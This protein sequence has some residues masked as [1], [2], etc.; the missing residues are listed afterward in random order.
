MRA[1]ID[2][3]TTCNKCRER[4]PLSEFGRKR[5][6]NGR[7]N[8]RSA[9]RKCTGIYY[10]KPS[11]QAIA[12]VARRARIRLRQRILEIYG[13]SCSCCGET[14]PIYLTVDHVNG[15]KAV[16]HSKR[17]SGARLYRWLRCHGFPKDQFRLLCYNCNNG[18]GQNLNCPEGS[19]SF[20]QKA[21]EAGVA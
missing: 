9:C 8:I 21:P 19:H 18:R 5:R 16:G 10:R 1:I 12:T 13:N 3:T 6:P 11:R 2:G 15:K 4:K 14:N 7:I 17:M 20:N